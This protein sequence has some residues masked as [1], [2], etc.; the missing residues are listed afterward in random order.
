MIDRAVT[1]LPLPDSPTSP[2][3]SPAASSK[4]TSLT[5]ATGPPG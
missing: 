4:L 3:V 1:D 5:A 2:S